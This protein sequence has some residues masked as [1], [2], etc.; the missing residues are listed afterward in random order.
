MCGRVEVAVAAMA[1]NLG[2]QMLGAAE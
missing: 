1:E 2:W